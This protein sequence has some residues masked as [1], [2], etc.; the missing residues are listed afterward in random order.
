MNI[1]DIKKQ[2]LKKKNFILFL[3][4]GLAGTLGLI[5]QILLKQDNAVI[6]SIGV[7]LILTVAI[8]FLTRLTNKLAIIFPYIVIIS[9]TITATGTAYFYE[10][11]IASI[12]LALF[13]LIL[14]SLHNNQGVFLFGYIFSVFAMIVNVLFDATGIFEGKTINVFFVQFIMALGIFLQVRQSKALFSNVENLVDNAE[15]KAKEEELHKQHLQTAVTTIT[16]NLEQVRNS[17][18]ASI[19]SQQEMLQA[20]DEVSIGSQ[21]QADH[22]V[23]IVKNTEATTDSV[24]EMVGHLNAIVRQA[25]IAEKNAAD[26]SVVMNKMKNDIDQFTVFFVELNKTFNDLSNKINETN[27]FASTIRKITEQTNLLAL[28]AS[29]EAARAGEQGKGFAVVAEEIRKLAGVTDQSLEKIDTNLNEVNKYNEE[30]LGK[31]ELGVTQIYTQVQTADKS[32]KSFNEL[33]ETMQSLQNELSKFLK[34]VDAIAENSEAIQTSTNE[35]AAIIEES[36]AAVEELNATLVN[37][38]DEQKTIAKYIDETYEE[39]Q[40]I[41]K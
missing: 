24:K 36:T 41:K 14:S 18:H 10:V 40:S 32:N 39:T 3:A 5:A 6:I 30:A 38:T 31:L 4:Y 8:Y 19:Y 20:V 37:I 25:E 22:V 27:E 29:I 17:T 7:P 1:V 35:F 16:T 15:M 33:F 28:N 13:V 11:S 26:G 12:V 21:R 23:D 9:G 2:D 34:D